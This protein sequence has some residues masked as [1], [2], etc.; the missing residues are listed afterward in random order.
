MW[1]QN[2]PLCTTPVEWVGSHTRSHANETE[3]ESAQSHP[4]YQNHDINGEWWR[5]NRFEDSGRERD[6]NWVQWNRFSELITPNQL[7]K[8]FKDEIRRAFVF[9]V[10]NAFCVFV[11]VFVPHAILVLF[12]GSILVALFALFSS[13]SSVLFISAIFDIFFFMLPKEHMCSVSAHFIITL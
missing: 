13:H 9:N 1:W 5:W 6:G 11:C 12:Y 4:L 2:E 7:M 8:L 10:A 3:I